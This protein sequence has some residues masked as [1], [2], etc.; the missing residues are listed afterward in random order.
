MVYYLKQIHQAFLL[1]DVNYDLPPHGLPVKLP[2]NVIKLLEKVTKETRYAEE[3]LELLFSDLRH[4]QRRVN[5]PLT[6]TVDEV[7][8]GTAS[9][10]TVSSSS[11]SPENKIEHFQQWR[12]KRDNHPSGKHFLF[13]FDNYHVLFDDANMS[14][15]DGPLYLTS[16]HYHTIP[17]DRLLR[18]TQ[19]IFAGNYSVD[20]QK[21]LLCRGKLCSYYTEY[22]NSEEV[23][24]LLMADN[25]D[26]LKSFD[27]NS[28]N[29]EMEMKTLQKY[30]KDMN[31]CS[32]HDLNVIRSLGNNRFQ[33]FEK[34]KEKQLQTVLEDHS[35]FYSNPADYFFQFIK[36]LYF[37]YFGV[38]ENNLRFTSMRPL[39]LQGFG[40]YDPH[41]EENFIQFQSD[42]ADF[43][44]FSELKKNLP[45]M[46]LQ[47]N[48]CRSIDLEKIM[49]GD[50]KDVD[51]GP[52]ILREV[53]CCIAE[54][55]GNN[56]DPSL[57]YT[58]QL[59][60]LDENH[61][62]DS[63]VVFS[64]TG[65]SIKTIRLIHDNLDE[66][67]SSSNIALPLLSDVDDQSKL[68]K[69]SSNLDILY[70]LPDK[71][72]IYPREKLI[73]HYAKLSTF[74]P[75]DVKKMFDISDEYLKQILTSPTKYRI[76][77]LSTLKQTDCSQ[78]IENFKNC[79]VKMGERDNFH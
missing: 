60:A 9:T 10:D 41:K 73:F 18:N 40:V 62:V 67:H 66:D 28:T 71:M 23:N 79:I 52:L 44:V 43:I 69:G 58:L 70:L 31:V 17:G 76:V 57:S 77:L 39:L 15:D 26:L 74:F 11:S 16:P 51:K 49:F 64:S 30:L 38:H 46:R 68:G 78:R 63:S 2:T 20:Y 8:A 53:A 75:N 54:T 36:D 5:L 19:F 35:K 1:N 22:L 65:H 6:P 56:N 55:Q 13:F 21:K 34:L 25:D 29:N 50:A 27:L 7:S 33:E 47:Q 48:I 72:L 32:F 12:Q 14:F 24:L 45:L 3:A 4:R 42:L 59:S 61:H 37:F